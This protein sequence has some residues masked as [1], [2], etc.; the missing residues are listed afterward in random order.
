MVFDQEVISDDV[1]RNAEDG[2][3]LQAEPEPVFMMESIVIR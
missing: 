1:Q 3:M 2:A